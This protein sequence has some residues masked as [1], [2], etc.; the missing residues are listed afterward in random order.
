MAF[1]TIGKILD[2]IERLRKER[3]ENAKRAS[4]K[5]REHYHEREQKLLSRLDEKDRR[6]AHLAL[7]GMYRPEEAPEPEN[8][9]E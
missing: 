6:R 5:V 9:D 7:L 3:E 2:R 4:E 1:Y 8:G